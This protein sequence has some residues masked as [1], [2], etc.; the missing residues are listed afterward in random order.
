MQSL[1]GYI[2]LICETIRRLFRFQKTYKDKNSTTELDDIFEK[3]MSITE[4][5]QHTPQTVKS[6]IVE[7]LVECNVSFNKDNNA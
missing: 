2:I 7:D 5:D 3:I 1:R 6:K 4:H